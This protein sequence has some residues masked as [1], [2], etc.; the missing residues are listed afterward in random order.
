MQKNLMRLHNI[1]FG[2]LLSVPISLGGNRS[3]TTTRNCLKSG[4]GASLQKRKR[5]SLKIS[6]YCSEKKML[7][8]GN[9]ENNSYILDAA[10]GFR[11]NTD[12]L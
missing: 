9:C 3:I 8:T 6:G 5:N 2:L 10:T 11:Q 1:T 7:R 12:P 4:Y